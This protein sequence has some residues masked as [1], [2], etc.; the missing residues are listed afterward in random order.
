MSLL[1]P[2]LTRPNADT[3]DKAARSV[4]GMAYFAGTGPAGK[5]CKQCIYFQQIGAK[6]NRCV[7]Y[8]ELTGL[9]GSR[10]DEHLL[11]CRYFVHRR[12]PAR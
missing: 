1:N 12:T 10:I 6:R 9:V 4:P 2:F 7:K 5:Q 3:A 11:A 8:Q